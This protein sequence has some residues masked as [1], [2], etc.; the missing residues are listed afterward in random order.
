MGRDRQMFTQLPNCPCFFSL[1]TVIHSLDTSVSHLSVVAVD[2]S[3]PEDPPYS[4]MSLKIGTSI[5]DPI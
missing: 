3:D 4:L 5:T 2:F 1:C